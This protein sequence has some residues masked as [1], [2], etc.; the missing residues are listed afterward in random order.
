M[1]EERPFTKEENEVLEKI[2][3]NMIVPT[4]SNFFD[5]YKE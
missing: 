3:D 2:I 1:T 5:Y 4:Q